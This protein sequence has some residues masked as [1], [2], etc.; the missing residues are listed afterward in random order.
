M[1]NFWKTKVLDFNFPTF[2][3]MNISIHMLIFISDLIFN[4]NKITN[5]IYLILLK[6]KIK[7]SYIG[8]FMTNVEKLMTSMLA[9]KH[10]T[11]GSKLKLSLFWQILEPCFLETKYLTNCPKPITTSVT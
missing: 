9:S 11:F 4:I 8:K 1:N 2:F 3:S 10:A 5:K 7:H 6:N